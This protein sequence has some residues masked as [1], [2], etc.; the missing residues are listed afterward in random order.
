[1]DELRRAIIDA[2]DLR[3]DW[4]VLNN[5]PAGILALICRQQLRL[6]RKLEE[7]QA[8]CQLVQA[9]EA[10]SQWKTGVISATEAMIDLEKICSS[11]PV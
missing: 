9:R 3:Q 8:S 4:P 11:S 7:D 5:V 6:T 1:M 2:L 10:V